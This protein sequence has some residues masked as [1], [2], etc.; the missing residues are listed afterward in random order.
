MGLRLFLGE[1]VPDEANI[2]ASGRPASQSGRSSRTVPVSQMPLLPTD[3]RRK[4]RNLN[5]VDSSTA[6]IPARFPDPIPDTSR[7]SP[8]C[9]R[10][11]SLSKSMPRS[12]SSRIGSEEGRRAVSSSS[13]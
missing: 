3:A 7:N 11:R 6:G 5:D 1:L 10:G 4:G 13:D 12:T 8:A 9:R 2:V